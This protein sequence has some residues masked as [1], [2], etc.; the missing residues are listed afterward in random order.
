MVLASF[1]SKQPPLPHPLAEVQTDAPEALVEVC[2]HDGSRSGVWLWVGLGQ[3]ACSN[4]VTIQCSK[5]HILPL[6]AS[7]ASTWRMLRPTAT[8]KQLWR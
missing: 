6:D 8:S 2:A 4:T 3:G 1:E 5:A 7:I